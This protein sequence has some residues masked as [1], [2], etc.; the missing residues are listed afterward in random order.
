MTAADAV[1]FDLDGVLVD[2]RNAF[3][4]SVNA[5]LLT[6]GLPP[7]PPQELHRYLGPPLHATFEELAGDGSPAVDELVRSYRDRYRRTM[8]EESVV[9]DGIPEAL[10]AL[11]A[12]VPLVVVT[13]KAQQLADPLLEALGLRRWFGAVVGPDLAARHEPKRVTL[14]RGLRLLP[15]HVERP[16][17]VGDRLHDVAA[18]QA[19]G[20]PC[21]GALWG[22][23]GAQELLAAG[24]EML[25]DA[26]SD[27]PDLLL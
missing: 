24:A 25:A 14:E 20:L 9:F 7:R 12:E 19:H 11:S 8:A 3:A 2:S 21:V 17:M 5:A 18:A 22:V 26:P 6:H 1:L 4:T 27:L 13:S 16:V 15:G 10:A 23:G